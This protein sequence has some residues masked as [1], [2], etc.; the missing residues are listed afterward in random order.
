MILTRVFS[1]VLPSRWIAAADSPRDV[2]KH[3][4]IGSCDQLERSLS[5][6]HLNFAENRY[7]ICDRGET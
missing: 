7:A 1:V 5:S 2:V 4:S 3:G 6:E